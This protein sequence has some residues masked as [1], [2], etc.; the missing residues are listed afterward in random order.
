V[1]APRAGPL[2]GDHQLRQLRQRDVMFDVMGFGKPLDE[3]PM[4][5]QP[6]VL[7]MA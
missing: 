7:S 5:L 3:V 2:H 1:P 6:G 4:L